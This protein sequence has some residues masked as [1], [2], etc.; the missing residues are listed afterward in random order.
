MMVF[1][2][3]QVVVQDGKGVVGLDQEVVVQPTVLVVMHHG[4]KEGGILDVLVHQA[5]WHAPMVDQ[6]LG[7]LQH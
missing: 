3:R 4:C 6:H 5:L 1:Q 2:R 7:Q